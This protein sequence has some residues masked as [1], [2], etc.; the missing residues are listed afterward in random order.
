MGD[1]T[2]KRTLRASPSNWSEPFVPP[3]TDPDSGSTE[4]RFKQ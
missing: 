3:Q 1:W 4:K 2:G